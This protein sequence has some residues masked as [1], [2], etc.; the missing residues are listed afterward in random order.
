MLREE[1]SLRIALQIGSESVMHSQGPRKSR[2]G[3][4]LGEAAGLKQPCEGRV[5]HSK[6]ISIQQD[7][8]FPR[9]AF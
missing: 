3:E 6:K 8:G 1:R 9:D 2:I 7:N 5:E 4:H